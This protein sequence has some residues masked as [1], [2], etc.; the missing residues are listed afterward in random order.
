MQQCDVIS[1]KFSAYNLADEFINFKKTLIAN[2]KYKLA[3]AAKSANWGKFFLAVFRWMK[4]LADL[5][6]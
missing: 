3:V 5:A 1:E 4:N 2:R 6:V